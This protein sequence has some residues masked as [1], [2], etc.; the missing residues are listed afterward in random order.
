ML[1]FCIKLAIQEKKKLSLTFWMGEARDA[2]KCLNLC[3]IP[4]EVSGVSDQ[5]NCVKKQKNGIPHCSFIKI[6]Y[7][8]F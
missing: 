2:N 7:L 6:Q 5:V 8:P 1:I 3:Y 4:N